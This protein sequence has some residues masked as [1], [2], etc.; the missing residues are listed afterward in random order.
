M[1]GRAKRAAVLMRTRDGSAGVARLASNGGH[2]AGC[3]A[4]VAKWGCP[5][6]FIVLVV[7]MLARETKDLLSILKGYQDVS[8]LSPVATSMMHT[9]HVDPSAVRGYAFGSGGNVS[10]G[11]FDS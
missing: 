4:R 6:Q 5:P 1:T 8:P 3:V 7:T 11:C 9:F 2:G 10:F